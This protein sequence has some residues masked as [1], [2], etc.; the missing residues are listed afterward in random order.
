MNRLAPFRDR[1]G[2]G[3]RRTSE[4][5]SR[6]AHHQAALAATVVVAGMAGTAG[7]ALGSSSRSAGPEYTYGS[8]GEFADATAEVHV[9][10]TGDLEG[11]EVWLDFTVHGARRDRGC[12]PGVHRPRRDALTAER[13][14]P[15]RAARSGVGPAV[16][17]RWVGGPRP[18][19]AHRRWGG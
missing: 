14:G 18:A 8:T 6:D 2:H 5:R 17:L 10:T 16:R 1:W 12:P 11:R 4:T 3:V 15:Q 7:V 13:S 9:V 19:S